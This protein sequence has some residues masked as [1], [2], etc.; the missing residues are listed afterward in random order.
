MTYFGGDIAEVKSNI[1]H[2]YVKNIEVED[3]ANALIRFESGINGVF[4]ATNCHS[5][6][7]PFYLELQFEKMRLR[8]A[9]GVLYRICGDDIDI[10][11]RD[12]KASIGKVYWGSGHQRVIDAFY[13]TLC[14]EPAEYTDIHHARNAMELVYSMYEKGLKD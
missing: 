13:S 7:A 4:S 1:S 11:E 6:N 9:D 5:T 12:K 3:N 14:G 10:I 2:W 8:Y